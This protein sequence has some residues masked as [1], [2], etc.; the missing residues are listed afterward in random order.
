[1]TLAVALLTREFPPEVY[2]GAGVHVAELARALAHLV[3]VR[4]HCFGGPRTSPLVARAYQPWEALRDGTPHGAALEAMSVDLA[5]AAGVTGADVVHSHT[6]HANLGGHLAK[7]L[8]GIPHVVTTHSLE[9]LR[10]WKA[11]QLGG[12]YALSSFCER[13]ALEAADAIIAVSNGMRDDVL[14]AY[15]DVDPARVRVVHNGV[16]TVAYRRVAP[17]RERLTRLGV[18]PARP[19]VLFIGRIARQK[20]ILHLVEAAHRLEHD[21]QI[22]L[23]AAA[24]DTDEIAREVADGVARLRDRR[25][26]VWLD[27]MLERDDAIALMSAATVLVCPSIYEP[28]GLV[29]LEAMACELAVVAT[30]VGGIPEVVVDGL[31]GSLVPLDLAPGGAPANPARFEADL[32]ERIDGLLGDPEQARAFGRAGRERVEREFSWGTLAATT[33]SIY[34][35]VVDA[36]RRRSSTT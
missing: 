30:S 11:E 18:D 5:M 13:T 20:G 15:P 8:H 27:T 10:P 36:A 19:M 26:V 21:A 6:W 24:P 33:A 1:V 16:D 3:D 23:C 32:A 28:F 22:V 9:P 17:D 31:T 12:G 14:S 35:E 34:A 4:I 7:L 29:N 2:G 25:D